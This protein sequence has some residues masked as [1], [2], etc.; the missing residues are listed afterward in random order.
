[1]NQYTDIFLDIYNT[2]Y[3]RDQESRS[4]T[5]SSI[6][7]TRKLAHALP[8][9]FKE[10]TITS[11][12]DIPCGDF[13]WMKEI[14]DSFEEYHGGDI[15]QRCIDEN[16]QKFANEKIKFSVIDLLTD[17]IPECDLLIVRDV[18]GHYPLKDGKKILQNIKKSKVKY[19]LTTSWY[20][21]LDS[22]YYTKHEN[23]DVHH[24]SFYPVNLMSEPFNLE[25]PEMY[26]EEDVI[27]DDYKKGNRKT[28]SLWN[29]ENVIIEDDIKNSI[30]LVTGL[31]DI[32][33]GDLSEGWS[34]TF[35]HYL[36]KF[37]ELL[38]INTNLII[39][40]DEELEKI[41]FKYRKQKNTQF[42]KRNISW[43]KEN[44]FYDLIQKI[45]KNPD[46][47]NQSGWISDSTQCK[48]EMYNPLVMS[49]MFLLHD[50]KILDK[51]DSS[52]LFWIDAGITNTVHIGYFTHDLVLSKIKN[53]IEKFSFIS[54]P[55]DGKIEIHGFEYKKMCEYSSSEVD[56]VCRGGFFGGTKN[57]ISELNSIY[58]NL[59]LETLSQGLMGT[60]ESIFTIMTYRHP[61][62]I[63]YFEIENNGLVGKFFENAKNE[64]LIAKTVK[65]NFI[66]G[67]E[68]NIDNCGLYVIT[69]NSP[70][71]FEQLI[72]SMLKYD[73]NFIE[74]PKKF[75]LDNST[76]LTTTPKY[77]E[78][79]EKYEFEHIKKDN[80]GITGGRQFI[81]EHFN[82]TDLD[83]MFFFEDDMFFYI[84]ESNV[85]KN[86][87]NRYVSDFYNTVLEITKKENFDFLKLNFTEFYGDN[88]TQWSW[89]NVPQIFREQH[90]PNNKKL[91]VQGLDPNA[92]KTT[93][94]NIKS[95]K[96]VPYV[97]GE[98]YLC[99]WPIIFTKKGSYKCYIET[100][101]ASP[102]EQ[103]LMSHNFQETIKGNLNPGLLSMTPTEHN[104]F[105]HYDGKLRK[106]N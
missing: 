26:I 96:G 104:R 81:A 67:N 49:K 40:G 76:D 53:K 102:F 88:S 33:R 36:S 87:F 63:E 38:K 8:I 57:S 6:A 16:N 52:H 32:G 85:C 41:V 61:E 22:N 30:T 105:D 75:L 23:R 74:K 42:V 43:F 28:L 60:E 18:I 19:L 90:W 5:G 93:F 20:N 95:Y 7:K 10:F 56:M 97:D 79:C 86:G 70:S 31:W 39:F 64:T 71:Q 37:I 46:W 1:M 14:V 58:Y 91:P 73:K 77:I 48:L 55:Y 106:E 34:R 100:K 29:L 11:I 25:E 103:T 78:L 84:G 72:Q 83:F 3:W 66:S 59:V 54:F 13:N 17:N 44:N 98:I 65:K 21:V 27:V 99:N 69:F 89:Y 50:A 45:R 80:I 24:G 4:G 35:D 51:F 62:L 12:L 94:K 47:Y 68:G 92:P 101:Y 15:L 82:Q 9:L 2:N